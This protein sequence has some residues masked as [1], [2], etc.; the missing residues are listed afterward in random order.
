MDYIY[1]DR[2]TMKRTFESRQYSTTI[3]NILTMMKDDENGTKINI[4]PLYQRDVVWKPEDQSYF[5][6]SIMRGIGPMPLLF[7]QAADMEKI[8]MDG[9]QRISSLKNFSQNIISWKDD[10]GEERFFNELTKKEKNHFM[11]A[12]IYVIE[13]GTI[14]YE[15]Q[16]DI[17]SRIQNGRPLSEGE[18]IIALFKNV[19]DSEKFKEI[20]DDELKPILTEN[21]NCIKGERQEHRQFIVQLMCLLE[22]G[23]GSAFSKKKIIE[24]LNSDGVNE[25]EKKVQKLIKHT[26][27]ESLLLNKDLDNRMLANRLLVVFYT[28]YYKYHESDYKEL[29]KDSTCDEIIIDI[30]KFVQKA[31]D[32]EVK[33]GKSVD[34]MTKLFEMICD[35]LDIEIE[36]E[37]EDEKNKKNVKNIE[38]APKKINKKK[39]SNDDEEEMEEKKDKKKGKKKKVVEENEDEKDEIE[40]KKDK[41]KGK[42]KKVVEES[43]DEKDEHEEEKVNT[44]EEEKDVDLIIDDLEVEEKDV[45][46]EVVEEKEEKEE[47]VEKKKKKKDKKVIEEDNIEEDNVEEKVEKKKKKKKKQELIL[48]DSE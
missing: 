47:K 37:K 7:C 3:G 12:Q 43:E 34:N 46:E 14:S 19:D 44:E 26:C 22:N 35:I 36:E 48:S 29:K 4:D 16:M 21:F 45:E 31:K 23:I 2:S 25:V 40:E 11:S 8:C 28:L 39:K 42:K 30:N 6:D 13:Y 20:C 10:D 15:D 41:K 27:K 1:L 17:F 9:K 18:K 24:L 38:K 5:I 32:E 33:Q